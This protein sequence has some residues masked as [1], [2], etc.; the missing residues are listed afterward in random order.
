M[1]VDQQQNAMHALNK[2]FVA[3]WNGGNNLKE[4][5]LLPTLLHVRQRRLRCFHC[6]A[7]GPIRPTKRVHCT[8]TYLEK[9]YCN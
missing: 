5:K 7:V 1:S 2:L 3:F 6:S 9:K 4:T 8:N